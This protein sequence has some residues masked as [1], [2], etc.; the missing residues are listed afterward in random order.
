M[1][2]L[3]DEIDQIRLQLQ[4]VN[5]MQISTTKQKNNE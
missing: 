1:T 5:Q 2:S 3:R 4:K